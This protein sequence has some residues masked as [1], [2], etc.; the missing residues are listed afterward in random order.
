MHDGRSLVG[1]ELETR[2]SGSQRDLIASTPL[3]ACDLIVT[4]IKLAK[5]RLMRC[6]DMPFAESRRDDAVVNSQLN[7]WQALTIGQHS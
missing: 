1:G 7:F 4:E 6:H 3:A 2:L 5:E